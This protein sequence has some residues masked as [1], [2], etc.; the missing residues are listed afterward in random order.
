MLNSLKHSKKSLATNIIGVILILS[1][2]AM[3]IIAISM[4]AVKASTGSSSGGDT[5]SAS[6]PQDNPT[7]AN[8]GKALGVAVSAA[9]VCVLV[10]KFGKKWWKE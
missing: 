3:I 8:L 1:V 6:P 4:V 7:M 2:L 5:E 9:V 10:L